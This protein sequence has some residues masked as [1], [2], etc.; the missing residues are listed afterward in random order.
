[1]ADGVERGKPV[2]PAGCD[3]HPK[4]KYM[5]R[6][7]EKRLCCKCYI[8]AGYPPADWHPKCMA[9]YAKINGA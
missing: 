5:H 1:M 3:N 8:E 4:E 7:G 9:A 6:A 2:L